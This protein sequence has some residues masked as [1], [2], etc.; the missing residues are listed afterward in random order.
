[1]PLRIDRLLLALA[2]ATLAGCGSG[3]PCKGDSV[4]CGGACVE[5]KSDNL[6]CGAC[7]HA[8]AA[9]QVCSGGA[10]ALSCQTGL[11]DCGGS[12]V[13]PAIDRG[14]CGACGNACAAGQAC[15][16]GACALSCQAGLVACSGKCIDPQ[17]DR[18][19]C[20]AS[21]ACSGTN[22]GASC[23]AGQV[24]S[25]GACALSCPAGL[26]TCN[27]TCIDPQNDRSY[28]GATDCT[29]GAHACAAGQVCSTGTCVLS[30]PAGLLT[31]NS[32]CVDPQNDRNFCGATDCTPGTHACA[33][34]QVCASGSCTLS[35][36]AGL[37]A[38][39]GKCVDPQ[40]DR[41]Y[42]G[43][44]GDC[45]GSN[46]GAACAVDLGCVG[47]ACVQLCQFTALDL[48][49]PIASDL[50]SFTSAPQPSAYQPTAFWGSIPFP[51]PTNALWENL[52][53][54]TGQSRVD[55]VP[56]QIKAL[57]DGIAIANEPLQISASL[58]N[59]PDVTRAQLGA[60]QF[61]GSTPHVVDTYDL[62]SV[63]LRYT[64]ASG[65]M[66][67]PLVSG[68]PYVSAVYS[69]LTPKLTQLNLLRVNGSS[70]TTITGA[71]FQLALADGSTWV[72]YSSAPLTFVWNTGTMTAQS[73][74][75]GTLRL[76]HLTAPSAAA[77]LDAHAATVPT[78]GQL[79]VSIGCDTA[80][81]RF[82]YSTSGSGPLLMAAMPHHLA[83]LQAPVLAGPTFN[84]LSGTLQ[85]VEGSTWT[86]RIPLSTLGWSAQ[87]AIVP[88]HLSDVTAALAADASFTPDPAVVGQDPYF[89]GKLLAKLARLALIADD[90]GDT[91]TAATLRSRLKPLVAA[92]LDGTNTNPLLYDTTWGGVVTT[93]GLAN[94]GADFGQGHYNDHH[95]HYGYHL[96]AA[97]VLARFDPSFAPA[98]RAGLNALVRDI[99]N[100]S[101]AD[102]RFPRFRHMDFFRGHSWANGLNEWP[103]G[104]NQE[105][106][107]EAVNAWYGL[108]LLGLATGDARMADLGRLLLALEIDAAHS[109]WQIPAA[110]TVYPP[111]YAQNFCVGRLFASQATFSTWFGANP[112]YVYGIQMLPFTPISEELIPRQWIGDAW[113]TMQ[114]RTA[115]ATQQWRGL[116]SMAH[117]TAAREAAWGE[118]FPLTAW[119]DGNSKTN[120]L[121]WVATRP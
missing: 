61:N 64:A 66:V 57:P 82:V 46:A 42:C 65:S 31:C 72:L 67:A 114:S 60:T 80:A 112:E 52:V 44:N 21:G 30:C 47:G 8:C 12:C 100:P 27:G 32:K 40:S 107:S 7:G 14:H 106:T 76:A 24:C 45:L 68:M 63:T 11:L 98:H 4:V 3:P 33:A 97:A 35:C 53:L 103:D 69:N 26:L 121:W 95:F 101:A 90:L 17:G 9:G 117:A 86:M 79:Q 78:G 92:W 83:R 37:L 91:G 75:T 104:N 113:P 62:F 88:A 87:R 119:D 54:G 108:H 120:T 77:A 48:D 6:N 41:T 109:Y 55:L 94:P 56:Y 10:C 43:A 22:A 89:G 49:T 39:N 105:S 2:V 102:P 118:V 34:G 25:G 84:A 99:A 28:C 70:T 5:A 74:F 58:V 23:A 16:G 96:Y 20:G 93:N 59:V 71:R 51:R 115:G 13:D 81:L 36:Q 29:P 111:A 110:S 15:S 38:C 85:T 18:L 116:L 19:H 50:P 1:M 73:P